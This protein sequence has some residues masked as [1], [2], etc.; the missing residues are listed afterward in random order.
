[1]YTNNL[2]GLGK[3]KLKKVFKKVFKAPGKT[4]LFKASHK[5]K[6]KLFKGITGKKKGGGEAP[7]QQVEPTAPEVYDQ[8]Y[9]YPPPSY[10]PRPVFARP[11]PQYQQQPPAWTGAPF[12]PAPDSRP[13]V[14]PYDSPT[15]NP[16]TNMAQPPAFARQSFVNWLRDW[17]PNAYQQVESEAPELLEGLGAEAAAGVQ[18]AGGSSWADMF[19][20]IAAPALQIYQQ[21]KVMQM[22]LKRAE[23]GL[24]PL[25]TE[26]L[27]PPPMAAKIG[28][29]NSTMKM[30]GFGA[31]GLAAIVVLPK[32][33]KRRA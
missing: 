8:G 29:D 30:I 23:Q 33:M 7:A 19:L 24:P 31:V 3:L 27:A 5:L 10:G 11:A 4:P 28:L 14:M 32:L 6:K 1:M 16:A 15:E 13:M 12:G 17:N 25:P 26:Q 20:K 21:R 9:D 22:Q 2:D 18:N